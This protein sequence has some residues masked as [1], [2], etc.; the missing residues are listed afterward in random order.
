L[1]VFG[2]HI[3]NYMVKFNLIAWLV[4][5]LSPLTDYFLT[6]GVLLEDGKCVVDLTIR[7]WSFILPIGVILCIN[8]LIFCALLKVI[9]KAKNPDKST[10][11]NTLKQLKAVAS[12]S[13]M[14]GLGWII[15]FFAVGPLAPYVQFGFIIINGTQGLFMFLF[16]CVGN[17]QYMILW[18]AKFGI[19]TAAKKSTM[20][21]SAAQNPRKVSEATVVTT[22]SRSTVGA[23]PATVP[24][25]G[26]VVVS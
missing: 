13:C 11:E 1:Q 12:I 7:A 15:A 14:L 6:E 21:S 23:R 4:P 24:E 16:Y 5:L 18:K 8:F 2:G 9:A 26:P 25:A 20:S 10:T 19:K 22:A 3:S 17:E